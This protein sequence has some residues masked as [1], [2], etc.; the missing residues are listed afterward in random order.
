MRGRTR[1]LAIAVAVTII[2]V[3]AC[4]YYCIVIWEAFATDSFA[5]AALL[6]LLSLWI[7]SAVVIWLHVAYDLR[8]AL[9]ER[10]ESR[11]FGSLALPSEDGRDGN[12]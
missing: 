1:R 6:G 5:R 7:A 8:Q 4:N 3:A 12:V 10:R 11:A 2:D 9:Q